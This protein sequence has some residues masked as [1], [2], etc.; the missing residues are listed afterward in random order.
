[1]IEV[2]VGSIVTIF[3][4]F[5][6]GVELQGLMTREIEGDFRSWVL[7]FHLKVNRSFHPLPSDKGYKR[8]IELDVNVAH[9][10]QT[11]AYTVLSH[12]NVFLFYCIKYY[13]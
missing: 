3:S 5:H 2:M 6:P 12:I 10:R 4:S 13:N 9:F 11:I 8:V 7:L 1:M